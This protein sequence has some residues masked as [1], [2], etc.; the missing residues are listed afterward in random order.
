MSSTTSTAKME[1][2][3]MEEETA[4]GLEPRGVTAQVKDK[5]QGNHQVQSLEFH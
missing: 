3:V 1:S 5:S 2:E 4:R